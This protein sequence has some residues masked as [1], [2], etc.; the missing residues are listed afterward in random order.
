MLGTRLEAR[1]SSSCDFQP[2]ILTLGPPKIPAFTGIYVLWVT[3]PWQA[4][5][6][7]KGLGALRAARSTNSRT[8]QGERPWH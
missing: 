1:T 8:R 7:V 6:L 3:P 2:E 5:A 4:V